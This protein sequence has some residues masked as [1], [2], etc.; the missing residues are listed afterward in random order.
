[1]K[2]EYHE[3]SS[4]DVVG[5]FIKGFSGNVKQCESYYDS[6]KGQFIFKLWVDDKETNKEEEGKKTI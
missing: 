3:F 6:N 5:Y 2:I 4:E 1:M